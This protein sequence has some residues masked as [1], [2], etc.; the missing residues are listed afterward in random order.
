MRIMI[1]ED[2]YW[3]YYKPVNRN[4][5]FEVDV[6]EETYQRW[7]EVIKEHDRV[8]DEIKKVLRDRKEK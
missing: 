8:Q 2:E 6:S 3:P 1:D 7:V 4:T 5:G